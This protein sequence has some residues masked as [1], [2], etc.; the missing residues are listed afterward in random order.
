MSQNNEC[1][2]HHEKLNSLIFMKCYCCYSVTNDGKFIDNEFDDVYL[3]TTPDPI[4][5]E[6]FTLQV[7]IYLTI[8]NLWEDALK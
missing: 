5:L 8:V 3:V 2:F 4:P 7:M 1:I 6:A